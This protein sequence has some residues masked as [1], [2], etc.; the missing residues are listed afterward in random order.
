MKD[1][2]PYSPLFF[3]KLDKVEK[4]KPKEI[5]IGDNPVGNEKT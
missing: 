4:I 1:K 2:I 5:P 3:E